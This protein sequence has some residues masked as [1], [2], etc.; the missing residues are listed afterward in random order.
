M[1]WIVIR[2][3]INQWSEARTSSFPIPHAVGRLIQS[4]VEMAHANDQIF[5]IENSKHGLGMT[6]IITGNVIDRTDYY[7]HAM[8]YQQYHYKLPFQ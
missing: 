2:D 8:L 4:G 1:A 6:G 5:G 3:A 7:T